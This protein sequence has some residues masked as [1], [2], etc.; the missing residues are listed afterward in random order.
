M[1]GGLS[2]NG[3]SRKVYNGVKETMASVDTIRRR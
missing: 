1:I 3:A 2:T